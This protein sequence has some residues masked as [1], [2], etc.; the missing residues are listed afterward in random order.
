[1]VQPDKL[2]TDTKSGSVQLLDEDG[3]STMESD[4]DSESTTT[5]AHTPNAT[6]D[7]SHPSTSGPETG[8]VPPPSND[9]AHPVRTPSFTSI[10]SPEVPTHEELQGQLKSDPGGDALPAVAKVE[11]LMDTSENPIK[12]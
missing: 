8:H 12:P 5:G 3:D 11:G 6:N 4:D 9:P 2:T 1:M 10:G 7:T